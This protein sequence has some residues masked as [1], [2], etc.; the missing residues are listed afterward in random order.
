M[1]YSILAA[2]DES[3]IIDKVTLIRPQKYAKYQ[4]SRNNFDNVLYPPIKQ[5]VGATEVELQRDKAADMW[6]RGLGENSPGHML[7]AGCERDEF[8]LGPC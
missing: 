5:L 2:F 6:Q 3:E 4:Y 8:R 1:E 7:K